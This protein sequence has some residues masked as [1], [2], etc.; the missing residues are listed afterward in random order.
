MTVSDK[1][2]G[3]E[4]GRG[5]NERVVMENFF[6]LKLLLTNLLIFDPVII[7]QRVNF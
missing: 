4:K 3:K 1:K 5:K 7:L 6:F 2:E